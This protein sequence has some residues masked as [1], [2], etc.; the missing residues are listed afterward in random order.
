MKNL[1]TGVIVGAVIGGM[2]GTV[3]SDEIYD[4]KNMIVKKGKKLAKKCDWM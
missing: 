4:I 1:V 3:A 2:I